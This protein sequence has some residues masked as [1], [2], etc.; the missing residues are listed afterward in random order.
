ML[1]Y[2][3]FD[4]ERGFVFNIG[5]TPRSES[6]SELAMLISGEYYVGLDSQV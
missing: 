3:L 6:T 2:L 4:V 1:S 5:S